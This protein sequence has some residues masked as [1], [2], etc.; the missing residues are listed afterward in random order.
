MSAINIKTYLILV[1]VIYVE[2]K[3]GGINLKLIAS[4]LQKFSKDAP[5]CD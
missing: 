5:V 2:D 4:P 3:V 1:F